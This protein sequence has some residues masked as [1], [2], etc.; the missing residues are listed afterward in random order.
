MGGGSGRWFCSRDLRILFSRIH[1]YVVM[2][3]Q[4]VMKGVGALKISRLPP[5]K[6][7][8][9]CKAVHQKLRTQSADFEA[10]SKPEIAKNIISIRQA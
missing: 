6:T 4:D 9:G 7:D 1:D 8:R 3:T 5:A 10:L 2:A